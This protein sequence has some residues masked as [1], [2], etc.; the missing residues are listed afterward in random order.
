MI[1]PSR[2]KRSSR[3]YEED[4]EAERASLEAIAAVAA[5]G[6]A[7][8]ARG[9][10]RLVEGSEDARALLEELESDGPSRFDRRRSAG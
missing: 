3:R 1:R 4:L 10:F 9:G 8:I 2:C 5:E 7:A 6:R